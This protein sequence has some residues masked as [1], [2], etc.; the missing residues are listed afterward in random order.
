MNLKASDE[1]LLG[2]DIGTG[3]CKTVLFDLSG[4]PVASASEKYPL[5]SHKNGYVEQNPKDYWNAVVSCVHTILAEHPEVKQRIAAI[6]LTGQVPTD[7]FLDRYGQPL[8]N[9][10]S[11]QDTR[12][13]IQAKEL[14]SRYTAEEMQKAVGSNVPISASW[15]ASRLLWVTQNLPDIAR[16]CTTIL[17]PKDYIGYKMTGEYMSDGWSCKSTVNILTNTPCAELLEYLGFSPSHMPEIASWSALRGKLSASAADELGLPAGIPVANGCSDAPATM[18]GCGVFSSS[19]IG[20]NSCGTSEIVGVSTVNSNSCRE[21]MTIPSSV[22]GSLSIVYG[23]TQSGSSSLLWYT[24][25]LL[26]LDTPDKAF[27]DASTVPCGADGL[28]FIPYLAGER[29]PLWEANVR[30]SFVNISNTHTSH[31]FA[32]AILEGVGFSVRHCLQTA[33]GVTG[34]YAK[35]LRLTGGGSRTALWRQIKADICKLPVEIM[36]CDEACALGAAMTAAVAVGFFPTLEEASCRMVKVT[37]R[38]MPSSEAS[39]TY[40]RLFSQYLFEVKASLDRLKL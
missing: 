17:M 29:A 20:F 33:K 16:K 37:D 23:P 38:I 3:S 8:M 21:L 39:D 30:G 22:T 9:G 2:I 7:I 12:A 24:G 34:T 19:D 10:I 13:V 18:L 36:K 4:T 5:Y 6:G 11:W 1:L 31:H 40:D 25:Q 15:S 32:R 35:S 14:Q 28:L 26:G 27:T